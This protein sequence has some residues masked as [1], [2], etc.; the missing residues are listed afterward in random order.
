MRLLSRSPSQCAKA[1]H[2]TRRSRKEAWMQDYRLNY[3]DAEFWGA[4]NCANTECP[5]YSTRPCP[6]AAGCGGYTQMGD[7]DNEYN[8]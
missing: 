5:Y 4:D 8:D 1:N 7:A 3:Y 2:N 6:A